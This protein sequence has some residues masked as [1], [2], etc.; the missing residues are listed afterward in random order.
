MTISD[1]PV[2]D[3]I[4]LLVRSPHLISSSSYVFARSFMAYVSL[5]PMISYDP[6][7]RNVFRPVPI[8]LNITTISAGISGL[9]VAACLPRKGHSVRVLELQ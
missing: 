2:L 1:L 6:Y 7:P 9:A 8:S 3:F 5:L 4:V